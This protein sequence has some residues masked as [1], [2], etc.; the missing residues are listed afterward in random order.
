MISGDTGNIEIKSRD[1]L[2]ND[3]WT[4]HA[5]ARCRKLAVPAQQ[6][7]TPL[8]KRITR[9]IGSQAAYDTARQFG[10]DYGPSFQLLREAVRTGERRIEVSLNAPNPARNPYLSYSLHP[11]SV[12]AAFHGL[13]AVFDDLSGEARGAPY[14]PVRF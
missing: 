5:I 12:D 2:S 4:L 6:P 7:P 14:I 11:I 10:L 3:D 9:P 8:R 1:R 13:V